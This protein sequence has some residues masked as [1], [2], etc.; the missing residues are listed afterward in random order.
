M[1]ELDQAAVDSAIILEGRI[2]E[3]VEKEVEYALNRT[4]RKAV[5]AEVH[6]AIQEEK[7][8]MMMEITVAIGKA[9]RASEREERKPLWESKPEDFGLDAGDLRVHKLSPDRSNG[10]V[11]EINN[12]LRE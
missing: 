6:K 10:D 9:M 8:N 3:R 4:L 11:K 2:R 5:V 7:H 1:E 12:A